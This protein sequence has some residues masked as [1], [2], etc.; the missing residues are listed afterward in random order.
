VTLNVIR[1]FE[2]EVSGSWGIPGRASLLT[3]YLTK[4]Q[5]PLGKPYLLGRCGDMQN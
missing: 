1:Y 5:L 4:F 2:D 3:R